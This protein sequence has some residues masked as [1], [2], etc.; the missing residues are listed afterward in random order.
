VKV[1]HLFK[2]DE[3]SVKLFRAEII[4]TA[5]L[6]HPNI[7]GFVGCC[8]GELTCLVLEWVGKGTLSTFL[9]RGD[10]VRWEEPLLK[11]AQDVARGMA[12]LHSREVSFGATFTLTEECLAPA[13]LAW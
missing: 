9:S 13:V 6:R 11:V 10:S 4:L 5:N 7:V 12:Y 2:V 3:S 1:P 8:W